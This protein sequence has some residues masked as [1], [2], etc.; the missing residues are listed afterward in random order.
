MGTKSHKEVL[1]IFFLL[2]LQHS[3]IDFR[4]FLALNLSKAHLPLSKILLQVTY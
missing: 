4:F 2:H 1:K 3:I